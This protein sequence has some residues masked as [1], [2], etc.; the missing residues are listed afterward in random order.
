MDGSHTERQQ[1]LI[2]GLAGEL[3]GVV[4]ALLGSNAAAVASTG[5][6]A[7]GWTVT[8]AMSGALSGTF[9]LAVSEADATEL[10]RRL[11]GMD[12]DPGV[13]AVVDTLGEVIG[14]AAGGLSQKPVAAGA[15]IRVEGS[16]TRADVLP[17]DAPSVFDVAM[18]DG[19]S[20]RFG[21]WARI[22]DSPLS[23]EAP[24]PSIS[25][26]ADRSSFGPSAQAPRAPAGAP[27][28][29]IDNLEV[30]LDIE[31]PLTVRFGRTEMTL[32]ALTHIGPGSVIDLDRSPDE[33]VDVLINDK[34]IARGEVVVVAG[35]YGVR[36]TEVMSAVERIR[37]LG[38]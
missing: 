24:S 17:P 37:S 6:L 33:P 34:I 8:C 1:E 26:P 7:A 16:V 15:K 18:E 10:A 31:L 38:Q 19:S 32:Q 2:T 36:V 4:S 21:C 5:P 3:A 23:T 35:N 29:G 22:D 28:S 27:H 30:I 11:M 9:T 14:Q 25:M 12:E 20:L 13:D